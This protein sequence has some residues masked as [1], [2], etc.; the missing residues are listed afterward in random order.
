MTSNSWPSIQDTIVDS[1]GCWSKTFQGT[2]G[3]HGILK[4]HEWCLNKYWKPQ[5]RKVIHLIL[6]LI[7]L[8]G[9]TEMF[10]WSHIHPWSLMILSHQIME[11][12]RRIESNYNHFKLQYHENC[13]ATL[14]E[15]QQR[16]L[17]YR[18]KNISS[19]QHRIKKRLILLTLY[20]GRHWKIKQKQL[21]N[22]KKQFQAL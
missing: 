6:T 5:Y 16:Y 15:Q 9:Y 11:G 3:F 19:Q 10:L 17:N 22:D 4:W 8:I 14:I 7:N 20:S 1:S 21:R 12:V 13:S 18:S 2:K